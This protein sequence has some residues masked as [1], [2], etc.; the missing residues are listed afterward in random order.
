MTQDPTNMMEDMRKVEV[1]IA[2]AAKMTSHM[3]NTAI[4]NR[5]GMVGTMMN[6]MEILSIISQNSMIEMIMEWITTN[7]WE[8]KIVEIDDEHIK[9]RLT[10]LN[11]PQVTGIGSENLGP[12]MDNIAVHQEKNGQ[13]NPTFSATIGIE[14]WVL[15]LVKS[16]GIDQTTTVE[17]AMLDI[18]HGTHPDHQ[19]ISSTLKTTWQ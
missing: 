17:M 11:T 18:N 10:K 19:H 16:I 8:M 7:P 5:D 2:G 12:E 14:I 4:T 9:E 6:A 1:R 3:W 13:Q 15:S